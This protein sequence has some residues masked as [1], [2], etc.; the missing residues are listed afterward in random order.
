M[1]ERKAVR[2]LP[3]PVGAAT[4]VLAPPRMAG[5]ARAWAAVGA[6]KRVRNQA[7]TA[8]WKPS[9][10][11]GADER[12]EVMASTMV[13]PPPPLKGDGPMVATPVR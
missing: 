10:A 1:A 9:S 13:A 8:G 4:R 3:E 7:A 12:V 5:Q 6:G 2:V 11:A